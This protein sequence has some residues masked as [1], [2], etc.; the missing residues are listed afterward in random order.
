MNI[1][2]I[3]KDGLVSSTTTFF[4]VL[5]FGF[6]VVILFVV[7]KIPL[8][9][10]PCYVIIGVEPR[11]ESGRYEYSLKAEPQEMFMGSN[12]YSQGIWKTRVEP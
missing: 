9:S 6:T 2:Y 3:F 12:T 8:A 7:L 1:L 4:G 5:C 11:S 10:K